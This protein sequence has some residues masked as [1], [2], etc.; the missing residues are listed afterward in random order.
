LLEECE[1]YL[2]R[3]VVI[4]GEEI[5]CTANGSDSGRSPEVDVDEFT[6][7]GGTDILCG[8]RR[9][10]GSLPH[11]A[12]LAFEVGDIRRGDCMETINSTSPV[13]SHNSSSTQVAQAVV[14]ISKY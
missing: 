6:W 1:V 4:A 10:P 7:F 9:E 3:V 8:R 2:A 14:P 13:Q 12:G 5:A 11:D